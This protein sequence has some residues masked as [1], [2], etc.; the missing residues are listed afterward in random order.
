VSTLQR[1]H[2]AYNKNKRGP[3]VLDKAHPAVVEMGTL[4][5]SALREVRDVK[6]VLVSGD[7]SRKLGKRVTKGRWKG[8]PI[9]MLTLEERATCPTSCKEWR[10]CYGNRSHYAKRIAAGPELEDALERELGR[11]QRDYPSGFVVRL[12]MLGDFYSVEYANKW[13]SWLRMFPALHVFGYTAHSPQSHIGRIVNLPPW[14]RWAMRFSG[15]KGPRG[16]VV[17]DDPIYKPSEAIICP[18]Q[19]GKTECCATCG[20]CWQTAKPIAFKRH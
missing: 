9:Y 15:L 1:R 14:S 6:R 20:L 5:P 18:A 4:F 10:S 17:F 16:A 11:L 7:N 2:E 12:H 19:T 8:M 3:V 13:L